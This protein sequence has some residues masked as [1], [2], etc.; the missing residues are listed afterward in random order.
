[1]SFKIGD[2]VRVERKGVDFDVNGMGQGEIWDNCWCDDMD[3][4]IGQ[5][6]KIVDIDPGLGVMFGNSA[7]ENA[8]GFPMNVLVA[9]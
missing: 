7:E 5:V 6:H 8:Y 3:S 1:M 2:S 9:A 4:Y